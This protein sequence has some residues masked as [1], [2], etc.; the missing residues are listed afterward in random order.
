MSCFVF[1]GEYKSNQVFLKEEVIKRQ[2][3]VLCDESSKYHICIHSSKQHSNVENG[4]SHVLYQNTMPKCRT[5]I[6]KYHGR[7]HIST[8]KVIPVYQNTLPKVIPVQQNTNPIVVPVHQNTLPKVI[9]VHQ[10][11]SPKVL[12]GQQNTSPKIYKELDK[13]W[14]QG[15]RNFQKFTG[16]EKCP[17]GPEYRNEGN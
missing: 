3:E 15:L 2:K 14:Q 10:N 1:L 6:P 17:T 16:P 7:S 13:K 12:P 5:S 9:P 8:S 4:K 11:T